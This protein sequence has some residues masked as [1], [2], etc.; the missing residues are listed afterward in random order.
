SRRRG[1]GGFRG[2]AER[3]LGALLVALETVAPGAIVLDLAGPRFGGGG[4]EPVAARRWNRRQ[5]CPSRLFSNSVAIFIIASFQAFR[6]TKPTVTV[7]LSN[8]S[9]ADPIFVAPSEDL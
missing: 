5:R 1:G 3:G 4:H 6:S 2:R 7:T 8:N 9:P